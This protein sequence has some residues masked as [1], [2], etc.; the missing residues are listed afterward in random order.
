MF[1][2]F[3]LILVSVACLTGIY[4]QSVTE[5]IDHLVAE[6]FKGFD[7]GLTLIATQK[8]GTVYHKA[9]G[10]ADIELEVPMELDHIFR[11]GS[12][13]K[14]FTA[15]AILSLLEEG[16][17]TLQDPLTKY[18]PG[19]N[20]EENTVTIEHLLT[21]TSG[22]PSYTSAPFWDRELRKKDFDPIE[23]IEHFAADS[24]DFKPGDRWR[25][26][27]TGYFMLGIIIE[28][29]SGKSYQEYIQE[30]LFDKLGMES[31]SYGD[32]HRIIAN[33]ASGYQPSQD[34]LSNADYLRLPLIIDL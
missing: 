1:K 10:Q 29:V 18:F 34:G 8:G 3:I 26:N 27:N 2:N 7:S 20:T 32:P 22:I 16:K 30:H 13:T 31:S 24:M 11:I 15:V 23:L 17:L 19:Y 21:H 25:Y 33:R 5:K 12:I 14:Q 9:F 4:G 6:K 28:Q